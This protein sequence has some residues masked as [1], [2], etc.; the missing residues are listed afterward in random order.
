MLYESVKTV[1]DENTERDFVLCGDDSQ[2]LAVMESLALIVQHGWTLRRA[3]QLTG[4]NPASVK[5]KLHAPGQLATIPTPEMIVSMC[6]E[7]RRVSDRR[8]C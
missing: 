1:I 2:S 3:C 6:K 8:R 7:F 5:R 4:A